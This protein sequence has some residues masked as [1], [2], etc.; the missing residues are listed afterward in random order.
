MFVTRSTT[1]TGGV[2]GTRPGRLKPTLD[3]ATKALQISVLRRQLGGIYL[4][5][6]ETLSA[7]NSIPLFFLTLT[8][9]EVYVF[10]RKYRAHCEGYSEVKVVTFE[11][12]LSIS[13]V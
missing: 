11:A 9:H 5:S 8:S 10:L 7:H 4:L 3:Y 6:P 13:T 1:K 2:F 12:C